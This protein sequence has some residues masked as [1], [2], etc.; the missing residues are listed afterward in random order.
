MIFE[1]L[2]ASAQRGELL[3]VEG[4]MCHWHLRRDGQLTILEIISLQPGVG[5]RMLQYL[6]ARPGAKTLFAKC[7]VDL[8]SNAWWLKRG[9][10]LV[11]TER[12]RTGRL[13]NCYEL[14]L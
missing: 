14:K 4:G 7:P 6:A 13:L 9:F 2:Y 8:P 1:S 5:S 11:R 3:L 12:T 10:T